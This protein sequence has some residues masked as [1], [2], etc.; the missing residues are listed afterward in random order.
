MVRG[1]SLLGYGLKTRGRVSC[2]FSVTWLAVD[3]NE[4][5][6]LSKRVGHIV[7]S[8]VVWPNV[9]PVGASHRVNLIP[10]PLP[11]PTPW[12]EMSKKNYIE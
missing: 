11:S 4:P 7:P 5:T 9:S 6:H 8:V 2:I 12:T 1:S 3:I 10:P